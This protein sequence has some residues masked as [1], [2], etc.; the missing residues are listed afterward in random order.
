M[1]LELLI[2]PCLTDNY[3]YLL[4]DGARG[5]VALI[6][7][8]EAGPVLE[9]LSARGWGLDLI[10]LTHHHGDHIAGVGEIVAA[11]GARVA[12]AAADAHRLPALDIALRGGDRLEIAGAL[13]EVIEVPGHTIGHIAFHLPGAKLL[14]SGDSL[15]SWGCGRL[16][17][18]APSQMLASLKRMAALPGETLVCSGH[19]YTEANGRF[20]LAL[21]PENPD[22]RARMAAVKAARAAGQPT[23][24][25]ALSLEIATNP[26]LRYGAAELRAALGLAPG[27]S[28]LACFTE[29]RARKDRF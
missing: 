18:G 7:A 10:A 25:A 9:A 28:D 21:E 27:A 15:M 8:P 29:A 4:R 22:L 1:T 16:F 6:D 17:E 13:A 3:A 19:E 23:V 5:T 12:G 24:P 11:T 20:A 14:F 2:L 26:F